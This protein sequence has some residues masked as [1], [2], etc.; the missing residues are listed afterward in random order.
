MPVVIQGSS[1]DTTQTFLLSLKNALEANGLEE[2]LPDSYFSCAV[3]TINIWKTKYQTTYNSFAEIVG[4]KVETFIKKLNRFDPEAYATFVK[5]YPELTSGSEFA[6]TKGLDVV[7]VYEDVVKK[8]K[9]FGY[10]G[11]YVVYDEFSKFLENSMSKTSA[12]E[13][14]MIQDFAELCNRSGE[15]QL[16]LLLISH[17]HIQNYIS[18]LPKEKIDAWKAVAERFKAIEIQNNFTQTYEIVSTV[19]EK[20]NKWFEI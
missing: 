4:E 13:I 16:H 12:M 11:I 14:K 19:I 10:N 17:K 18:Q 8:I 6:P 1:N 7:K 3:D 9:E 5:I 20:D 2:I 15:N